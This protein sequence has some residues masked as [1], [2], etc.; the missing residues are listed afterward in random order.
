MSSPVA[1]SEASEA[2]GVL[3]DILDEV[4]ERPC[5]ATPLKVACDSLRAALAAGDAV[6]V[7]LARVSGVAPDAG[8]LSTDDEELW[9]TLSAGAVAP[10]GGD[11]E[12]VSPAGWLAAMAALALWGPGTQADAA[13]L[14]AY[15]AES[16]GGDPGDLVA[17]LRPIVER[18]TAL[19][20]LDPTERLTPLGWWGLLEAQ[21]R[22]W[23]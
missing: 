15:I 21:L 3:R 1:D 22:V 6:V 11:L 20:A 7:A 13:A 9:L 23:S 17:V 19:G 18:W 4:G 10:A 2:A 14:A 8:S 12:A 16:E 5:P